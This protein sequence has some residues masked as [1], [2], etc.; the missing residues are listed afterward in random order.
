MKKKR[1]LDD[2]ALIDPMIEET[3]RY[4]SPLQIAHR[5]AMTDVEFDGVKVPAGTFVHMCI[6]GANRDPAVFADPESVDIGRDPN[7]HLAFGLGK[8]ICMGN[9]LGRIEGTVAIGRFMQKFP[10]VER[11]GEARLHG[12]VKF[13]GIREF[14]VRV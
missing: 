13:R 14:P 4:Q 7:P 1:L 6:A 10:H 2:P 9:T 12:R 5:K 3:L 11:N 8:H